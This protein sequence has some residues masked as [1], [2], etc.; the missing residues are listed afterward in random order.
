MP[1]NT[2]KQCNHVLADRGDFKMVLKKIAQCFPSGIMQFLSQ[3][4][5]KYQKRSKHFV[6]TRFPGSSM[7]CIGWQPDY[8][9]S[10]W[11]FPAYC[12]RL[13]VGGSLSLA[14]ISHDEIIGM[15]RFPTQFRNQRIFCACLNCAC[16]NMHAGIKCVSPRMLSSSLCSSPTAHAQ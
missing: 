9:Q 14:S 10:S 8:F 16:S 13:L 7:F 4:T 12:L 15:R 2:R 5:S 6:C 11:N 1:R 3:H